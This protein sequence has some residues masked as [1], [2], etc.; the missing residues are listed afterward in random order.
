MESRPS[1]SRSL[2]RSFL[3]APASGSLS[4]FAQLARLTKTPTRS[5]R[6]RSLSNSGAQLF[7]VLCAPGNYGGI[8][9]LRLVLTLARVIKI[10]IW[11]ILELN[12]TLV[13]ERKSGFTRLGNRKRTCFANVSRKV[14]RIDTVDWQQWRITKMYTVRQTHFPWATSSYESKKMRLLR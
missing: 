5:S 12:K 6:R 10:S 2:A 14:T 8:I 9:R 11:K 13:A 4:D 3:S 1:D 7:P